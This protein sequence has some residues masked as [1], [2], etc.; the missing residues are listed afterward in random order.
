MAE[1]LLV[2]PRRRRKAKSSTKSRR[3]RSAPKAARRRRRRTAVVGVRRR[4]RSVARLSN[5][6]RRRSLTARFR[7]RRN[8]SLR[9]IT[10]GAIP[11]LK[12]GLLGAGGAIGLDLL[13][14]QTS[15]FMPASIAGSALAQYAA[16]LVGA[17]IIGVIGNKFLGGRGRD[18]AV[19]AAT[20]V[21]HD[22]LKAQIQATLPSVPLGEYLTYA[23]TVGVMN[24]A[25]R[26]LS[27]GMGEYLSGL[28]AQD[29]DMSYS[30][31]Y[32]GDGMNGY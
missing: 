3:R 23:P 17:L 18:M 15:K 21:L 4:R 20:V 16:K 5:P 9:G 26:I 6:R 25:G 12:A 22:A 28:P 1:I 24:R 8:P 13:W 14:G 2:N 27:T 11:T 29:D 32:T 7:R 30:G 10:S 31:E 19:G